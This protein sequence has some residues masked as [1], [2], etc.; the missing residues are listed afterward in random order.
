MA[1][2]G[3]QDR[4]QGL[5]SASTEPGTQ[6]LET[7]RQLQRKEI[8]TSRQKEI[9]RQRRRD[10]QTQKP[11]AQMGGGGAMATR[12]RRGTRAQT[13]AGR[14][15]RE[16]QVTARGQ[17][18]RRGSTC[19]A[20]LA[21]PP[22][23]LAQDGDG[24]AGEAAAAPAPAP[25]PAQARAPEAAP[26]PA[27]PRL[28]GPLTPGAPSPGGGGGGG[29]GAGRR[30]RRQPGPGPMSRGDA[31]RGSGLIALTFCLLTARGKGGRP[32]SGGSACGVTV[33]P[34]L[35]EAVGP[36]RPESRANGDRG[37]P[38]ARPCAGDA[39]AP[40]SASRGG[41]RSRRVLVRRGCVCPW[42][43]ESGVSVRVCVCVCVCVRARARG[44]WGGGFCLAHRSAVRGRSL[45]GIAGSGSGAGGLC[46][47]GTAL[48]SRVSGLGV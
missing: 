22:G 4:N 48:Y 39:C 26:P 11:T 25:A 45:R 40:G 43:V 10:K 28:P 41:R 16:A 31:G 12:S 3:Y 47:A 44:G 15:T 38:A 23:R 7:L 24:G 14:S 1:R 30:R 29:R 32:G 6:M 20:R 13:P 27:A 8:E 18:R 46:G 42:F 17:G 34:G 2:W 33:R 35:R 21:P 9:P 19:R 37:A 5:E 36:P